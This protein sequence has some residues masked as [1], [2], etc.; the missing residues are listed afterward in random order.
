MNAVRI[1]ELYANTSLGLCSGVELMEYWASGVDEEVFKTL[2]WSALKDE[3]RGFLVQ[4]LL[5][6]TTPIHAFI[7]ISSLKVF[8][9]ILRNGPPPITVN[10]INH[11]THPIYYRPDAKPTTGFGE[12]G[13]RE[14]FFSSLAN[15][16]VILP[17]ATVLG[18]AHSIPHYMIIVMKK[19]DDVRC[20]EIV[21]LHQEVRE[22]SLVPYEPCLPRLWNKAYM[23]FAVPVLKMG[24]TRFVYYACH[25]PTKCSCMPAFSM[26]DLRNGSETIIGGD[27]YTVLGAGHKEHIIGVVVVE[28]GE[29]AGGEGALSSS[30]GDS[31]R[32]PG[33]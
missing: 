11:D 27:K 16:E 18:D 9:A 32:V 14:I 13:C 22:M 30:G 21:G 15:I 10:F 23:V 29:N 28:V 12:S 8:Y 5:P 33:K 19:V 7:K 1:E 17:S 20:E 25:Y 4:Y 26:P 24:Q 31:P 6:E 3:E 2:T